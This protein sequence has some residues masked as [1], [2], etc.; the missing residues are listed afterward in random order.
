MKEYQVLKQITFNNKKEIKQ[1]PTGT[2]I[3][4]FGDGTTYEVM[5]DGIRIWQPTSYTQ[6]YIC[7]FENDDFGLYDFREF[8]LIKTADGTCI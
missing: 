7:K 1:L 5:P 3:H 2:R 6:K 8:Y 4:I